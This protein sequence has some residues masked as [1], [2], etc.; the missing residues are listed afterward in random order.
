MEHRTKPWKKDVNTLIRMGML[1]HRL[2]EAYDR[3]RGIQVPSRHLERQLRDAADTDVRN[4]YENRLRDVYRST[5]SEYVARTRRDQ[6][7]GAIDKITV[8]LLENIPFLEQVETALRSIFDLS[9]VHV[10]FKMA[11]GFGFLLYNPQTDSFETFYISDH[12]SRDAQDRNFIHQVPNV[13]TIRN[14]ADEAQ[15][16]RDIE[17]S[18]FFTQVRDIFNGQNYNFFIVRATHMSVQLFPMIDSN[19]YNDIDTNRDDM[20]GH[21][22]PDDTSDE[23]EEENDIDD[24][25]SYDLN[26]YDYDDDSIRYP[27]IDFEAD[28]TGANDELIDTIYDGIGDDDD[29]TMMSSVAGDDDDTSNNNTAEMTDAEKQAKLIKDYLKAL[30]RQQHATTNQEDSN[31]SVLVSLSYLNSITSTP[32]SKERLSNLCFFYQL[33]FWH[34]QCKHPNTVYGRSKG[35]EIKEL[36]D[37]YNN[38]YKHF[39]RISND[40]NFKG[41]SLRLLPYLEYLF[42]T[43]INVFVVE[44][45]DETKD[46]DNPRSTR[47]RQRSIK[48]RYTPVLKCVYSCDKTIDVYKTPYKTLSLLLHDNRFYTIMDQARLLCKQFKCFGCGKMFGKVD[49]WRVRRHVQN[50]CNKVKKTYKHGMVLKHENMIKEACDSFSIPCSI[51]DPETDADSMY[52]SNYITFDFESLLKKIPVSKFPETVH[53]H[54][55][56][57]VGNWIRRG[58]KGF[59]WTGDRELRPTHPNNDAKICG[60][61]GRGSWIPIEDPDDEFYG[62]FKWTGDGFP[63]D[64][65]YDLEDEDATEIVKRTIMNTP[66]PLPRND[67]G[68]WLKIFVHN[69]S[70]ENYYF[71]WHGNG[72]PNTD[73]FPPDDKYTNEP[74]MYTGECRNSLDIGQHDLEL[75]DEQVVYGDDSLLDDDVEHQASTNYV[76]INVPLS[77]AMAANFDVRTL[78]EIERDQQEDEDN[79]NIDTNYYTHY[80]VDES[81]KR[82]INQFVDLLEK[83]AKKYKQLMFD[84]YYNMIEHIWWT[85][86]E[87]IFHLSYYMSYAA[88]IPTTPLKHKT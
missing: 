43:R 48:E 40:T 57:A 83:H 88:S 5:L 11:V 44:S 55:D 50:H 68:Y 73:N 66:A 52:T 81:P 49:F 60:P 18:D 82:L 15:V 17:S 65:A 69:Q 47:K 34:L 71:E 20:F 27:F 84:K 86:D 6:Y 78:N 87:S 23:E 12:L 13:W 4:E 30:S 28:E 61:L 31:H 51:F 36:G 76:S 25:G 72:Y 62:G 9:R 63:P 41:V 29:T 35:Q 77:F 53:K 75:L 24:N 1:Q 67:D 79:E 7:D 22:L 8:N 14:E 2:N 54:H 38:T 37:S 59:I 56:I 64:H 74:Q 33:A 58:T 10:P 26:Y 19:V 3:R 21:A 80:E 46:D 45:L 42:Q 39:Y 70:Y 32:N 85:A 16:F